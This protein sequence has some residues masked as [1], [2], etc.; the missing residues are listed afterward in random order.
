MPLC[1]SAPET[2]DTDLNLHGAYLTDLDKCM[3]KFN[4]ALTSTMNAYRNLLT[5][6]DQV[7]QV[8]GNV[9]QTC[10]KEV[11][12]PVRE[13]RDG[14][15]DLKDKGGFETFNSEI[16][17]GTTAA[18]EPIKQGLKHAMKSYKD[19]K[20]RQKEYDTVRYSLDQ[21]EKSYSKKDKP[22]TESKDYQKNVLKREKTKEVFE[23]R[24]SEFG[25][26]I[27]ALQ[28]TT[29]SLLLRSL[30][31]YLHC[32]ASFCGQLEA[33]MNSYRTDTNGSGSQKMS[34][35][36]KLK[37][38]A[39]ARSTASTVSARS[40]GDNSHPNKD[41]SRNSASNA[42][43]R[44]AGDDSYPKKDK[45]NGNGYPNEEQPPAFNGKESGSYPS[46]EQPKRGNDAGYPS[47]Q[48]GKQDD[49]YP[50]EEQPKAD[51]GNGMH[52]PEETPGRNPLS[53]TTD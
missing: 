19:V 46:E 34:S 4:E 45:I 30:N 47:E 7:G 9:A 5:A 43:A 11:S 51:G 1:G 53:E 28:K 38:Q 27:E 15:R 35:M 14:M 20:A 44:S 18:M 25:Q 2:V 50:A 40:G 21:K 41:K 22:L 49:F 31:N 8:Y 10:S 3:K 24:R 42:S 29:D 13:F 48:R 16:H 6:F 52:Y 33:T 39:Q 26:E 37:K 23:A 12:G 32:T 36:D 17:G